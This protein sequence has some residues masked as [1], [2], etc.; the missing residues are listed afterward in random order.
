MAD[1]TLPFLAPEELEPYGNFL[2]F[3]KTVVEGT[4]LGKHRSPREGHAVEFSD[5]RPYVPGEDIAKIDWR[6]Y[7]RTRHW[8]C[9]R[10]HEETDMSVHL[11]LDTS[12]SMDFASSGRPRKAELAS[13]VAAALTYLIQ[14]QGD[15]VSFTSFR[16]D[17]VKHHPAGGTRR[18]MM[19]VLSTLEK[20]KDR[21]GTDLAAS[22]DGAR[23]LLGRRGKLVI[24]SDFWNDLDSC[25]SSLSWYLHRRFEILLMKIADPGE[26][27][28]LYGQRVRFVDAEDGRR[29]DVH[30]THIEKAYR[31]AYDERERQWETMAKGCGIRTAVLSNENPYLDAIEAFLGWQGT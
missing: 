30:P 17:V 13:R 29:I 19:Q 24:L 9:R 8:I 26:R 1:D 2:L 7:A 28:L 27:N 6:I 10:H 20:R 3:A 21:G 12:A 25:F 14:K 11:L 22:L 4:Y 18:H 23:G 15:R 16:D 5:Y 31:K